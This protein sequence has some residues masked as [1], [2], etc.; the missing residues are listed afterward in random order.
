MP[1]LVIL[2]PWIVPSTAMEPLTSV[3]F[4][5]RTDLPTPDVTEGDAKDILLR[6]YNLSGT[7]KELGS[8]QDRNYRIETG[9]RGGWFV[10]KICRAEYALVELE[11]QNAAMRHLSGVDLDCR[12]PKVIPSLNGKEIIPLEIRGQQY[13][14]RLLSYLDGQPLAQCFDS[15][16]A[17]TASAISALGT[18]CAKITL[19]LADF[20][21]PGLS[22]SLQWD[23]RRAGPV[24][25]YLL[26][27]AGH[28]GQLERTRLSEA[29]SVALE[30]IQL[31]A[32]KLRVQAVHH[33]L[34]GDNILVSSSSNGGS[35]IPDG[36]IDFGDVMYGCVAGDLAVTCAWLLQ[37]VSVPGKHDDGMATDSVAECILPAVRAYH[38]VFTLRSE[39]LQ[40]LWPLIVARAVVLVA[41]SERQLAIDPSNEYVRRNL[42]YEWRIFDVAAGVDAQ[43][44]GDTVLEVGRVLT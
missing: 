29:M 1:S 39:E 9:R 15:D 16:N 24:V 43:R 41:S 17:H 44:M 42:E 34:T 22:R 12:V 19:N 3:S 35:I 32:D 21:H 4:L 36:V 28:V 14:A 8:Q 10:L 20:N 5:E 33:D 38:A 25:A 23:L 6:L 2:L 11:A 31:V 27:L 40:A 18:F 37:F 7:L 26:S 13:R 30:R